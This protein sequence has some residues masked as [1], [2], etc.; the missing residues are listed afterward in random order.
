MSAVIW[1]LGAIAVS[2]IIT[3]LA[4]EK[5]DRLNKFITVALVILCAW[6]LLAK[7][8]QEDKVAPL[9]KITYGDFPKGAD[10]KDGLKNFGLNWD[11]LTG[12]VRGARSGAQRLNNLQDRTDRALKE[13][14]GE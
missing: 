12:W 7:L 13:A 11:A 8:P 14:A 4:M 5:W 10:I 1:S 3:L 2:I 9:K 6:F